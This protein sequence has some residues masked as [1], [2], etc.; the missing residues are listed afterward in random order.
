MVPSGPS[1][2]TFL[3]TEETRMDASN[4]ASSNYGKVTADRGP[5]MVWSPS[6]LEYH[7]STCL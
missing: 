5:P 2:V 4:I 6:F 7:S 3:Y 1:L